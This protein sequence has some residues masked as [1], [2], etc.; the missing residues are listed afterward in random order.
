MGEGFF[1][2]NPNGFQGKLTQ[3]GE[4]RPGQGAFNGYEYRF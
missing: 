3:Y 1:R 4:K 2:R